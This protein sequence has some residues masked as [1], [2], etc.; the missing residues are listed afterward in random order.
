MRTA[1]DGPD[2][3]GRGYVP[4]AAG[5]A[6]TVGG[7]LAATAVSPTFDWAT[8]AL[9][10]LGARPPT[11]L[12]FN[13]A[14]VVGPAL[15]LPYALT[16][17][18]AAGGRAEG[19]RAG[20]LLLALVSTVGVGL[21]P[22]GTALHAPAAIGFFACATATLLADALARAGT[23]A[24]RLALAGGLAV[25]AAWPAWA[26]V[27]GPAAGVTDPGIAIPE[28]VGLAAF[29][30]WVVGLPPGVSDDWGPDG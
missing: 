18:A 23:L 5:V 29:V 22:S 1:D 6:V 14:L 25:P 27:V 19:V 30:A 12:L 10:D 8:G 21:F 28:L 7:I 16:L 3:P 24:G 20:A 15:G 2:G 26:L 11:A 17:A 4:A 9:S 13:G